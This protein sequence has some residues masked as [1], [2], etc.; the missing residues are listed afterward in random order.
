MI[1]SL[2][3]TTLSLGFPLNHRDDLGTGIHQFCLGQHNY[4][5]GKVPKAR[6]DQH[7]II[8]GGG[9]I[10][11]LVYAAYLT[12]PYGVFFPET[13]PM[14]RSAHARLMVVLETLIGRYH[15]S[16]QVIY[17]VVL[18]LIEREKELD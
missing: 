15:P 6:F 11:T 10:P 3:E 16:A 4:A 18:D 2:L 13:V 8:S 14:A 9:G 1:P 17:T 5:S 12:A 7:Q